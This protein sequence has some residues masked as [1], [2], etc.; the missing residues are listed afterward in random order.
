MSYSDLLGAAAAS[1][2]KSSAYSSLGAA[3]SNNSWMMWV[4][5]I[6]A[7]VIFFLFLGKKNEGKFTGVL[8]WLYEFLSFDRMMAEALIKITYLFLAIWITL[9]S[10]TVIGL[11]FLLFLLYLVGG[12]ILIRVVYELSIVLLKVCRNTTEINKKMSN[13]D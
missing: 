9:S 7:L 2:S 12:N 3:S 10:F 13:K 1:S 6:A 4:A 11:S 8:G 5:L